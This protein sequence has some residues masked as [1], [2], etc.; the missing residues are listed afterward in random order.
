[1]F[2]NFGKKPEENKKEIE[3]S[4]NGIRRIMERVTAQEQI[5]KI[6]FKICGIDLEDLCKDE[7]VENSVGKLPDDMKRHLENAWMC[8]LV[9][10]DDDKNCL[11]QKLIQPLKSGE[12]EAR[13]L[14]YEKQI[15]LRDAKGARSKDPIESLIKVLEAVTGR[16]SFLVGSMKNSQDI[17]TAMACVSFFGM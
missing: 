6:K 10:F 3:P 7:S 1:M 8:G 4:S 13:E 16:S 5:E 11:I 17:Q 9:Y 15:S 2:K 14:Y 12:Q